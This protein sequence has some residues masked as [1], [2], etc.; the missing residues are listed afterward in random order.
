M[1]ARSSPASRCARAGRV[2]RQGQRPDRRDQPVGA[3]VEPRLLAQPPARRTATSTRERE[4][5]GE[6]MLVLDEPG[7]HRLRARRHR[8]RRPQAVHRRRGPA[9][10]R[11]PRHPRRHRVG[12]RLRGVDGVHGDRLERHARRRGGQRTSATRSATAAPAR[13]STSSAIPTCRRGRG[14]SARGPCTTSRSRSTASRCRT[15]SRRTSKVSAT[16]T[17]P[18]ARIAATSNRCTCARPGGALFEATVSKPEG[19]M[20]DEPYEQLGQ[21]L[22]G[23]AGVRRAGGVDQELPRAVELLTARR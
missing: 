1:R 9:D 13:S 6:K 14:P 23:A 8:R 11:H 22:P 12:P 10:V 19:F 2:G 5:F 18:T 17:C 3:R 7:R 4:R 15:A 16:P 20:I 21:R